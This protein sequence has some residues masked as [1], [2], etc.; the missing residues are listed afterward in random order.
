MEMAPGDDLL[1]TRTTALK[2][3]NSALK[4]F[5]S[6]GGWSFNDP[7]TSTIFSQLVASAENTNTF[8]NSAL[9]TMQAYGFDGIGE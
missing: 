2:Q 7:P 8:I 6:V 1:W 9:A 5:L 3:R 4:V